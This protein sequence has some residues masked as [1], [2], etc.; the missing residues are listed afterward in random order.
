MTRRDALRSALALPAIAA[1]IRADEPDFFCV[2]ATPQ[3]IG[4]I[5]VLVDG[6]TVKAIRCCVSAGYAYV[7][8]L[9]S[10]GELMVNRDGTELLKE[11]IY[12]RVKVLW[13]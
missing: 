13:K 2:D 1:G 7:Y 5:R 9:N 4:K 10:K 6:K 11:V 8:V 12:G 3:Y